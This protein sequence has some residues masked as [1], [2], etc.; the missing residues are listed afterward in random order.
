[1][2]QGRVGCPRGVNIRVS[3]RSPAIAAVIAHH[4]GHPRL[5]SRSRRCH[6]ENHSVFPTRRR[7]HD[8][9]IASFSSRCCSCPLTEGG[10]GSGGDDVTATSTIPTR[11]QRLTKRRGGGSVLKTSDTRRRR[12]SRSRAVG[13][14]VR[15]ARGC[16]RDARVWMCT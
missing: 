12:F 7:P 6:R 4:G 14:Q 11:S 13:S 9:T 8:L 15:D 1:M 3:G 16:L 10:G 5:W 2:R